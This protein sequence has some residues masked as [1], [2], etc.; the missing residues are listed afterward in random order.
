MA[1]D[2]SQLWAIELFSDCVVVVTEDVKDKIIIKMLQAMEES[3]TPL[4]S[5][6][7]YKGFSF[8]FRADSVVMWHN[9]TPAIQ[10]VIDAREAT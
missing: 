9:V 1:E 5:G 2:I 3:G 6:K 10:D 8:G 4:I 7:D